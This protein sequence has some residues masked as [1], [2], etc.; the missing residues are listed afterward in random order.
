MNGN[1]AVPWKWVLQVEHIQYAAVVKVNDYVNNHIEGMEYSM[2]AGS[3]EIAPVSESH[4]TA[5]TIL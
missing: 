2:K 1:S 5:A 4:L 3:G